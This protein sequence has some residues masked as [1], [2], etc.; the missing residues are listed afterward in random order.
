MPYKPAERLI[1]VSECVKTAPLPTKTYAAR[2]RPVVF[3][4]ETAIQ[5]TIQ[6]RVQ[7][8]DVGIP[9]RGEPP[10]EQ[11][12]N[13][14]QRAGARSQ[15]GRR[16][17]ACSPGGILGPARKIVLPFALVGSGQI[18][19][20]QQR[21]CAA[22]PCDLEDFVPAVEGRAVDGGAVD[23][24][25]LKAEKI[26]GDIGEAV[27][28]D[29]RWIAGILLLDPLPA[30]RELEL[31]HGV[32]RVHHHVCIVGERRAHKR[33]REPRGEDVDRVSDSIGRTDDSHGHGVLGVTRDDIGGENAGTHFKVGAHV[34]LVR[35]FFGVA[36]FVAPDLTEQ[37]EV[38]VG[39]AD[40]VFYRRRAFAILRVAAA[41]P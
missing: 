32:L 24:G 27:M 31:P 23:E 22:E 15:G 5:T 2:G 12:G 21:V 6:P 19:R 17:G 11:N 16:E 7:R 13:G 20:R 9:L 30:S 35:P 37:A 14:I 4:Q 41:C 28:E 3:R 39:V 1:L 38:K 26:S 34:A 18:K 8:A 36:L 33:I 29:N 10:V 25:A 40:P